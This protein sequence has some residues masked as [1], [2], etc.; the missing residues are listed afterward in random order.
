MSESYEF[1]MNLD[2]SKYVG[3]WVAICNH[4]IVSHSI[5]F[6]ETYQEA[7]KVC[8]HSKPFIAMVPKQET[9]IL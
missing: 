2:T 4:K 3:E 8:G 1:F 9:M 5:S 6:K 7:K